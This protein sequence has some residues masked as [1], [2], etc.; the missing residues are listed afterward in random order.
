LVAPL[1]R[2]TV[3]SNETGLT[4]SSSFALGRTYAAACGARL[5]STHLKNVDLGDWENPPRIYKKFKR[6]L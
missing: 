1:I 3:G 6:Y 5:G 2:K 4:N